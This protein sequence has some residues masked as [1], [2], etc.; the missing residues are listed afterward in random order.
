[1]DEQGYSAP[2]RAPST[3]RLPVLA[4][5]LT[6]LV[7]LLVLPYLLEEARY[8]WVRAELRARHDAAQAALEELAGHAELVRLSDTSRAFRLVAQRIEP[9]VVHISTE[10]IRRSTRSTAV[11]EWFSAP[12][13]RLQGQGS[14]VI[15]DTDGHILTNYHVIQDAA[16]IQVRLSD[17]RIIARAEVL[18][19]DVL[20]DLAVLKIS[21]QG[22]IAA[23]WGDSDELEPGDWVLAIGNPFGLDRT[24]TSGIVSAKGRRGVAAYT[25]Y[26]DFLQ[27][28]AAVNPGSSGGPLVNIR[29]ELV[30][31]NTA[32]IGQ[33]YQGVSFAIPSAI[34]RDVFQRLVASGEV[35][36]G[37]MGVA[38][39]DLTPELAEELGLSGPQGALVAGVAEGSP[40]SAAGIMP[41][42]VILSFNKQVVRERTE[43][44]LM[45]AASAIGAV[46]PVELVRDGKPLSIKVTIARRP[47]ER[48][49]RR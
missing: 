36:R 45:V 33:S 40:A 14:G 19:F 4:T 3:S 1:M 38:L 6:V 26:Q 17:G 28:D 16:S 42:D 10:Q 15:V 27:T 32:I 8:R 34:A 49:L 31:I 25:P 35:A 46:V 23:P 9:S 47:E 48:A 43:L 39:R 12:R 11:D 5:L 13:Y 29:G 22:L 24:V 7:A 37:W 20:T 44:T 21:A 2:P 41:G 18:G 30:G